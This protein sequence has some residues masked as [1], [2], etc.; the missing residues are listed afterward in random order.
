MILLL[1]VFFIAFEAVGEALI[2]KYCPKVSAVVFEWWLQWIIVAVLFLVWFFIVLNF[3]EPYIPV[4]KLICGFVFVRFLTF[5]NIYN[6][7]FGLKWNYYGTTKMYDLVM[8][9]LG[10][11]GW[12]LK[13]VLG[14]V[15]IVFLMGWS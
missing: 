5:D 6:L 3:D 2:K 10:S 7:T 12:F 11:W 1:A 15:G 8:S 13:I 4:W 9:T 14:I